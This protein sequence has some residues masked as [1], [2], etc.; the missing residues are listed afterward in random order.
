M[1]LHWRALNRTVGAEY[2][3]VPSF[4]PKDSLTH[5]ALVEE[6]TRIRGHHFAFRMP[7][8]R[9]RQNRLDNEV[10]HDYFLTMEG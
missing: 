4:R 3:A 9:A 1:R 5:F 2:A 8:V 7:A 10:W 6:L